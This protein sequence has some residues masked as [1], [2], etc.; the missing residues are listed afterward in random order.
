[1]CLDRVHVLRGES[2]VG[3]RRADHSLL[4]R[5]VRSG[6]TVARAVLVDS[7]PPHHGEHRV[8]VATGV[9]QP[10][11]QQDAHSLGE[12]E[13][14]G[15]RGERLAA[16]VGGQAALAAELHEHARCRHHRRAAGEGEGALATAQ[17]LYREVQGD[18][19]GGAGRVHGHGGAFEAE[20]VG[21]AAGGD[22]AGVAGE[23]MAVAVRRFVQARAVVHG[24]GADVDPGAAA[25]Q[26][27]R[28]D[29]GALQGFPGRLQEE[30]LLRVHGECLA[31]RDAE[32]LGVEAVGVQQEPGLALVVAAG[33]DVLGGTGAL[34]APAA[35]AGERCHGVAAVGQE[36]PQAFRGVGAARVP[37]AHRDD[38]HRVVV[39]G[40]L[41][42]VTSCGALAVRV[43]VRSR[44]APG[45]TGRQLVPEKLGEPPR[46][47]VVE[48][49]RHGQ[50]PGAGDRGEA[51]ADLHRRHGVEAEA[52]EGGVGVDGPHV[53]EH[54]G[55]LLAHDAQ[56]PLAPPH[57]GEAGQV[58]AQSGRGVRC[59]RVVVRFPQTGGQVG[60]PGVERPE[61]GLAVGGRTVRVRL[62]EGGEEL[63][64]ATVAAAQR[65]ADV[66]GGVPF[67][68]G[69]LE[70]GGED[71]VRADL[72]EEAVAVAQ[73][74][75]A[76]FVE[77]DRAAQVA[78][79][80]VRVQ[81]RFR[82][83]VAG[84][85]GV[86]REVGGQRPHG[87][88]IREQPGH[89][90]VDVRGVRGESDGDPACVDALGGEAGDQFRGGGGVARHDHRA[91]PV[92]RG[93]LQLAFVV[94]Q[95]GCDIGDG[96][97]HGDHLPA[98]GEGG[99]R[100]APQGDD[101]GAV[102]EGECSADGRGGDLAAAVA[103]DGG[104]LH[105]VVTPESGQGDADGEQCGLY[106]VGPLQG[107]RTVGGT[108]HVHEGPV[109][110][111]F[112]GLRA[113]VHAAS[114]PR[115]RVDEP[116]GHPGPLGALAREDEGD[117]G[118]GPAGPLDEAGGAA[119][120]GQRVE[121]VQE[122]FG[123]AG[124][125]GGAPSRGGD[126]GAREGEPDV[127]RA[128]LGQGAQVVAQPSRLRREGAP[129]VAGQRPQ[130][131]RP[132]RGIGQVHAMAP[133]HARVATGRGL[134]G[135]AGGATGDARTVPAVRGGPVSTG[136]RGRWWRSAADGHPR[137][138]RTA[139]RRRGGVPPGRVRG[140][141]AGRGRRAGR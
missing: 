72:Q 34:G 5:S 13:P 105:T 82:E 19:R 68:G 119:P 36:P 120:A 27:V 23:E 135:G 109:D 136:P 122:L 22:T 118:V 129:A 54:G 75:R 47:G 67:G 2:R 51:V 53:A 103:Q 7:A 133:Q 115:H 94:G 89:D 56:Q 110:K 16:A 93:D 50:R 63:R 99:L 90:G 102:V 29:P 49:G 39:G 71:G 28:V 26:G 45:R 127:R 88:Q 70:G 31:G 123:C 60:G 61:D 21:D 6:Q 128:P 43:P 38:R 78:G 101:A 66:G 74:G 8:P 77:A 44:G 121:A 18:E 85:T 124:H 137:R 76:G 33:R 14:V 81:D 80:V 132:G 87:G 98:P 112:E 126:G 100:L 65:R 107:G 97:H 104:R 114:E 12:A 10:L 64:A 17:R 69:R 32:E 20:G 52:G 37:A 79:P 48:D 4:A 140:C 62:A 73:Q 116:G 91:R 83:P 139:T 125:E 141:W 106:D 58:V 15:P 35:V 9:R 41:G 3:Q 11:Q 40:R 134:R 25:A 30:P 96:S 131:G 130:Q 84:E 108:Q 111:G 24:H 59:L 138:R 46:G 42:R 55:D 57:G 117:G 113:G 1:M 86:V 95:A 92:D